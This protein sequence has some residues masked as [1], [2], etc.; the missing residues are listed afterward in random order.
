MPLTVS[1][2]PPQGEAGQTIPTQR[3]RLARSPRTAAG[4]ACVAPSAPPY[5][6]ACARLGI[7]STAIERRR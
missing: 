7:R 6:D 3:P 1:P 2:N 4:A 5:T